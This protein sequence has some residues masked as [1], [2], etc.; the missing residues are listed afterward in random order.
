M[1]GLLVLPHIN[2]IYIDFNISILI[3]SHLILLQKHAVVHSS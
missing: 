1:F 3:S 2:P